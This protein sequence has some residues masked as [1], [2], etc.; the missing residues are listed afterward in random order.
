MALLADAD[1]DR[2]VLMTLMEELHPA[3]LLA[4]VFVRV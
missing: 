1:S 3:L 4:K 2:V